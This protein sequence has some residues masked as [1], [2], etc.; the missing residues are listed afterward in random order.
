MTG[1]QA[2]CEAAFGGAM[3]K[4]SSRA[5]VIGE[6]RVGTDGGESGWRSTIAVFADQHIDGS[7]FAKFPYAR[8]QDDQLRTVGQCHACT[9]DCL[10]AQ[11]RAVKLM[12]IEIHDSLP[13]WRVHRLEVHFQTQRGGAVKALNIVADEK[14]AHCQTVV[15]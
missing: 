8:S 9:V 4:V 13:H 2:D 14:A 11:P 15:S 1:A 10:I 5:E 6:I 7:V 3:Y 12:R